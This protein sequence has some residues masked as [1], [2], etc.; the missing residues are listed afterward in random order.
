M[1]TFQLVTPIRLLQADLTTFG[2]REEDVLDVVDWT[3]PTPLPFAP[4]SVLGIV[5]V[6][7]RMFTVVDVAALV[8]AT[9]MSGYP[10]SI[11]AL[12]GDEQLAI[13]VTNTLDVVEVETDGTTAE[14]TTLFSRISANGKEALLLD[15]RMLFAGVIRGRERRIRNL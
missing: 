14:A 13:A 5:S 7:S 3:E 15:T 9:A 1:L 11:V 8:G 4:R 2:V 10:R 6:Q 12:R